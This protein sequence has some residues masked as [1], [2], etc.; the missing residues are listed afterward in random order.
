[1]QRE[2]FA[3][4]LGRRGWHS[5]HQSCWLVSCHWPHKEGFSADT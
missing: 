2:G 3:G 4:Q 5:Q 1:M